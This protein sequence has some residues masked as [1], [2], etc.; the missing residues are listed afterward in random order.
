LDPRWN[1][2][3]F[4]PDSIDPI[5]DPVSKIISSIKHPIGSQPLEDIIKNRTQLKSICIVVSDAT[6]PVPS[7][8]IIEA[9]VR[10]LK[11][12]NIKYDQI[13]ILIATG[14]HRRS[15]EQDYDRIV[16]P[17][18]KNQIKIISH[19]A[20]KDD[21]LIF[22]GISQNAIPIYINKYYIES[23]LRILTGYVEPHFF[24]GFSGG[25]KSIV[26]GI[27]GQITI[28][29][30][31]SAKNIASQYARF[32]MYDQ[33]PLTKNSLEIAE[34]VGTD[35]VVNV[36]INKD[37]KVVEVAA[38]DLVKVHNYLVEFQL[39]R[40]FKKIKK[41]YDIVIC[42]NGG[43]PLDLNLYQAV[44]SMAL[45]EIAVRKGGTIISVN[46]CVEGIG[47]G[48]D[49]FKDLLFSGLTPT[50]VNQKILNEEIVVPDQWEIQVLARVLQ[51]AEIILIS[52]LMKK[53][54]GNIGLK[55]ASD[56]KKAIES[57]V[58]KHGNNARILILPNGPQII[59]LLS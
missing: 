47:I 37:H 19:D 52:K 21:E 12:N 20:K 11:E 27:A 3:V 50:D 59:P 14:L 28:Q 55:H 44:K 9:L 42:G 33:N 26:P 38:G 17:S 2:D 1:V 25:S 34:K 16:G 45:G 57:S 10:I 29:E 24:F 40:V 13:T 8:Y 31:H 49:K 30:N 22:M 43:Y 53:E 56:L 41:P 32:G 39:K 18:L 6:R 51:K 7:H 48:Q 36:C 35:F 46:E 4:K 58:K 54:I 23:D 5:E 15:T